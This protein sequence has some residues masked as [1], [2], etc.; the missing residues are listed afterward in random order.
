MFRSSRSGL[1]EEQQ[2]PICQCCSCPSNPGHAV[3]NILQLGQ[4]YCRTW[5]PFSSSIMHCLETLTCCCYETIFDMWCFYFDSTRHVE[6]CPAFK[7][8]LVHVRTWRWARFNPPRSSASGS[9]FHVQRAE[10]FFT[11]D[12]MIRDTNA[13]DNA[14]CAKQLL[15]TR[16]ISPVSRFGQWRSCFTSVAQCSLGKNDSWGLHLDLIFYDSYPTYSDL[17]WVLFLSFLWSLLLVRLSPRIRPR[18]SSI[19]WF[20][21]P[22]KFG[23]LRPRVESWCVRCPTKCCTMLH[24]Y[25][26]L[27]KGVSIRS[28]GSNF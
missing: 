28:D 6:E 10:I 8:D 20:F 13:V 7:H 14:P 2:H 25:T 15:P 17:T 4:Y 21:E 3:Q 5:L 22:L 19:R 1:L 18:P 26:R 12:V 23:A 16:S 24:L 9:P 11:S 27:Y